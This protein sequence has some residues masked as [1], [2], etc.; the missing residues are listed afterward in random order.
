MPVSEVTW[1]PWLPDLAPNNHSALVEC[2]NVYPIANGYAPVGSLA[3][4]LA[5]LAGWSGGGA[6]V[7]SG[8]GSVL[9]SGTATDLYRYTG[10]A[11]V[12]VYA[13]GGG[14]WAFAQNFGY[15]VAVNG[16]APVAYDLTAG[17]A[18]EIVGAPVSKYVATVAGFTFLAGDPANVRTVTR[19]DLANPNSYSGGASGS[20]PLPEASAITGL[21]GGDFGLVFQR[22]KIHRFDYVGGA[23]I[24]QRSEISKNTGCIASGSIAQ[25]GG[26]TFFLSERGF[27]KC[28]G[29]NAVPIGHEKVDRTFLQAHRG[30][31][32]A[33]QSAADPRHYLVYWMIP[34][35]PGRIYCYNYM[36]DQW[37]L[38][39]LPCTGICAAFTSNISLDA[40]DVIYPGGL[41]ALALPL[42][43]PIFA[44]GDPR[45]YVVSLSGELGTLTGPTLAA[46][47]RTGFAELAP[48]RHSRVNLLRPVGDSVGGVTVTIDARKRLGDGPAKRS[49]AVMRPSGDVPAR[50]EG[51]SMSVMLETDAGAAW[52]YQQGISAKYAA[53]GLR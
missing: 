17:T 25:A 11:W 28:D 22:N 42:D 40:M 1:G 45:F 35:N 48:G 24:F 32:D 38:I 3:D 34:G 19:S 20:T 36:M 2:V 10:A 12:S 7:A 29:N 26:V 53:G 15:V 14:K 51:R 30:N 41:D 9:L 33:I 13:G 23:T 5:P 44:G 31:L 27:M 52:T 6:F 47:L 46:R 18:S 37:A 50:S 21:A 8:G 4:A 43:S 49:R 39:V 16:G